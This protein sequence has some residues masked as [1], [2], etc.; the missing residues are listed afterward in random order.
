MQLKINLVTLLACVI[1]FTF[2]S[3]L[4][5]VKFSHKALFFCQFQNSFNTKYRSTF[6]CISYFLHRVSNILFLNPKSFR[7]P[8]YRAKIFF[9]Y[10]ITLQWLNIILLLNYYSF[11]QPRASINIACLYIYDTLLNNFRR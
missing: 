8:Y 7:N 1:F 2:Y 6:L 4:L 5:K 11:L 10:N 9:I 3:C